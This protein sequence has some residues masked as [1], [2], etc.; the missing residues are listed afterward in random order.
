MTFLDDLAKAHQKHEGWFPSSLSYRNNNPGNLRLT[1][2]QRRV[3]GAV[4]GE[5]GFAHFPTYKLGFDALKDDLRAKLT[6]SSSH[7]DYTKN[8]TFLDYIKV[9]APSEDGNNPQGY[10]Q[11][12][13]HDLAQYNIALSTPLSELARFINDVAPPI[14][15]DIQLKGAVRRLTN[16]KFPTVI[17]ILK[18][19]IARIKQILG[20]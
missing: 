10:A 14:P 19:K 9:Y 8:P 1:D 7:I 16:E 4:N 12:L 2:Y 13:I 6:G 15:L 3:Y 17:F 5:G 18:N 20:L 11:S